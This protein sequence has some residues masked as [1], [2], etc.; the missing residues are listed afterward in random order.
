MLELDVALEKMLL[1]IH[2]SSKD[3]YKAI[4]NS[5][6]IFFTQKTTSVDQER[7]NKKIT[8]SISEHYNT[9]KYDMLHLSRFC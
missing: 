7:K 1:K 9:S 4:T 8:L 6:N 5:M 2:S 3:N